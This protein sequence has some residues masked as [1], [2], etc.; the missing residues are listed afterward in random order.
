MSQ[1]E[2]IQKHYPTQHP[3]TEE[4]QLHT[5]L[6][7]TEVFAAYKS[8]L[9]PYL[10]YLT[11]PL[12]GQN[13]QTPAGNTLTTIA[14]LHK[15]TYL[16]GSRTTKNSQ[17]LIPTK[18]SLLSRIKWFIGTT[19]RRLGSTSTTTR[20]TSTDQKPLKQN[21]PNKKNQKKVLQKK[22]TTP[23]KL[24]LY[25]RVPKGQFPPPYRRLPSQRPRPLQ[26]VC[27]LETPEVDHLSQVRF[28][29]HPYPKDQYY[30][31]DLPPNP[32]PRYPPPLP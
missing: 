12:F 24:T 11:E 17:H 9:R 16:H 26:A 13:S 20:Y 22:R 31:P 29:H 6:C 15:D 10:P 32:V 18:E 2:Q 1:W 23:Y 3:L 30:R 5:P 8:A 27:F 21:S 25:S 7:F 4:E 28:L 14:K 19:I